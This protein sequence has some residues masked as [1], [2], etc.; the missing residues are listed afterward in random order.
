VVDHVHADVIVEHVAV[1]SPQHEKTTKEKYGHLKGPD[2][3]LVEE[4]T[5]KGTVNYD[6][7]ERENQ[8]RY[9]LS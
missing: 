8:K 3:R 6:G 9:H 4:K 1:C 7:N 2:R 5:L